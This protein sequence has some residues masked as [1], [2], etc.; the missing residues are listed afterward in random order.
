LIKLL[1]QRGKEGHC[2]NGSGGRDERDV[3]NDDPKG[4]EV[5]SKK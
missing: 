2:R 1:Q 5:I 4:K 3:V